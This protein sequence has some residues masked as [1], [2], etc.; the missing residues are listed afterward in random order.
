MET[1][2]MVRKIYCRS[3]AKS[4]FLVPIVLTLANSNIALL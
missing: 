2:R 1:L 4:I 3:R